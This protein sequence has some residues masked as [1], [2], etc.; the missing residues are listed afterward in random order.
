MSGPHTITRH[1]LDRLAIVYVRQS[2]LTQV[3]EHAES[4]ARQYALAEE[5]ARLGWDASAVVTIDTD[6]GLS[7]RSASGRSGFKEVIS[8]VCVGEVFIGV[9]HS[10]AQGGQTNLPGAM[11]DRVNTIAWPTNSAR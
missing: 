5:A 7:G 2:T 8:R 10:V 4:T 11:D 3:R 9:G 1:H 6:L